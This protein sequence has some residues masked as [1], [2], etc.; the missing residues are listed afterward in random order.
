MA[1]PHSSSSLP[2]PPPPPARK[3]Q[4]SKPRPAH[5][6]PRTRKKDRSHT[7]TTAALQTLLPRPRRGMTAKARLDNQ[8]D[9]TS[10]GPHESGNEGGVEMREILVDREWGGNAPRKLRRRKGGRVTEKRTYGRRREKEEKENYG[11]VVESDDG[12]SEGSYCGTGR[13][14]G[15]KD[16]AASKELEAARRKFAEVDEWEMEFESADMGGTGSS[17]R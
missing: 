5:T 2:P 9:L 8:L 10:D 4:R 17:W 14:K 12:E 15:I 1:D 11:G 3:H 7:L 13:S 16:I 6:S